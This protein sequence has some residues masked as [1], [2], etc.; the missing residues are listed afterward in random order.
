MESHNDTLLLQIRPLIDIEFNGEKSE[1]ELFMHDTLRP[2]LK[3][4]NASIVRMI[5]QDRYFDRDILLTKNSQ[6]RL[7]YL[8]EYLSKQANLRLHLQGCII[9]MMTQ[10]E[11]TFYLDEKVLL[12]KRILEM[13]IIRYLST[14]E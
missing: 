5:E 7:K 13:I 12:N 9:G 11:L 4:Q 8:K 14:L 3:F 10:G 2:I 1:L 6:N